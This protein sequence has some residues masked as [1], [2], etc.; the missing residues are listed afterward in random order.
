MLLSGILIFLAGCDESQIANCLEEETCSYEIKVKKVKGEIPLSPRDPFWQNEGK[1]NPVII[2]LGPQLITNPQW[3]DPFVKQIQ[4]RAVGNDSDIAFLLSW[5]DNSKNEDF[6]FG[7]DYTDQVALMFPLNIKGE[8]P[9]ITMGS[10]GEVVNIW[11]WKAAWQK[12]LEKEKVSGTSVQE[13]SVAGSPFQKRTTP[14]DDLN[15]E[16]FS[17]LTRQD[18]QDVN[19][20]GFWANDQWQVVFKRSWKNKDN[21]DVQF[22]AYQPMAIAAW[23]GGNRETNGQKGISPWILLKRP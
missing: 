16:G 19:G 6:S 17:T 10:D 13:H 22:G 3:P 9:P 21:A 15:A 8:F 14:V 5:K 20:L 1:G 12:A 4:I 7:V 11:Q 2:E 18:E 23:N